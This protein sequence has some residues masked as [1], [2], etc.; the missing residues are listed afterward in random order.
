MEWIKVQRG[1]PTAFYAC[2]DE[3]RSRPNLRI[4]S[5]NRLAALCYGGTVDTGYA[6]NH[7]IHAI[8]GSA[9]V[10]NRRSA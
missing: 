7:D 8:D 9:F 5:E 4:S 6:G 1:V 3:V 2:V 10:T